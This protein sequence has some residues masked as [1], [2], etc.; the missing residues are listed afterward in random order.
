MVLAMVELLAL[1]APW[2][3]CMFE[4]DCWDLWIHNYHLESFPLLFF[5][6]SPFAVVRA[7]SVGSSLMCMMVRF[8]GWLLFRVTVKIQNS[9][10]PRIF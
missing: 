5:L 7:S 9:Q 3:R 6:P 2:M 8:V 1:A 4:V 10:I